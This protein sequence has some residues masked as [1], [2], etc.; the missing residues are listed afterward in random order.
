MRR[1]ATSVSKGTPPPGTSFQPGQ[2]SGFD[3]QFMPGGVGPRT[4]SLAVGARIYTLAGAGIAPPMPQPQLSVSLRSAESAQQGTIS[5]NFDA[6]ALTSGNGTVTLQFLPPT[7]GAS[8]PAIAFASGGQTMSFDFAAG[9]TQAT[10][11]TGRSAAFQTGTTAGTIVFL[12]QTGS[13]SDQRSVSIAAAPVA[14][15]SALASRSQGGIEVQVAGFDNTRTA[16]RLSFTFYDNGG[17]PVSPGAIAADA[18]V[19]FA[20]YFSGSSLGGNFLLRAVFPVMGD[21]AGI[22]YF[23][24]VFTNAAGSSTTARTALR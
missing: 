11:A 6:P 21:T 10:F 22:V 17:S 19:A 9:D 2:Q 16:G 14:F 18:T 23:Q 5:V 20:Q 13:M 24:A 4:G 3:V 12:A 1:A 7:A 8:D 15:G